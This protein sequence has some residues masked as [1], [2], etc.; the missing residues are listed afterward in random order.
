MFFH[1][2]GVMDVYSPWI[3]FP[4]PASNSRLETPPFFQLNWSRPAPAPLLPPSRTDTMVVLG[5]KRKVGE[6]VSAS[7]A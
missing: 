1:P 7:V 5:H 3:I 2:Q 6:K 4:S